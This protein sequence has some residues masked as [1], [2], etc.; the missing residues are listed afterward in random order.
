M[1]NLFNTNKQADDQYYISLAIDQLGTFLSS[2]YT[3]TELCI[4]GELIDQDI[5]EETLKTLKA[6]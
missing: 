4:I 1:I 2:R 5:V 6:A 3:Q